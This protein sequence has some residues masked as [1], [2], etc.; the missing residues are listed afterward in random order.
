MSEGCDVVMSECGNAM[1]G[2]SRLSMMMSVLGVL[3]GLAGVLVS[4]QVILFSLLLGN[5]M[6]MRGGVV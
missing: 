1:F 2:R 6:G 5:T 3:Q 4:R